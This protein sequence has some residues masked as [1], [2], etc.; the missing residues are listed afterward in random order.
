MADSGIRAHQEW[1]G[2]IQPVGLVVAPSALVAAQVELDRSLSAKWLAYDALL[3]DL[4]GEPTLTDFATFAREFLEWQPSQF[5][6]SPGGPPFPSEVSIALPELDARLEPTYAVPDPHREGQ[7]LLLIKVEAVGVALDRA[8]EGEA[9]GSAW[10]ASPHDRFERLLREAGVP[11][12]LLVSGDTIR[13]VYAPR[14][15]SSG[16]L[17]FPV[18]AMATPHGRP[19]L[20]ALYEMLKQWRL[21]RACPEAR[22]LRRLLEDSRKYQNE[23]STRLAEQVL[24]ALYELARGFQVAD[25]SAD[26]EVL[27][28]TLREA[29]SEIYGGLLATIMRLV[30]VLYAEERAMLPPDSAWVE[31]YGVGSLLDRLRA[32]KARYPDTMDQ[33]YGAWPRLLTLFRILHDGASHE[34]ILIPSRAGELFDPD[35]YPFLEGRPLH[36]RRVMGERLAR[37]PRLSDGTLLRVLER[38]LVLDEERLSYRALDVEQIG[39]VY[40]AMMGFEVRAALGTSIAVKPKTRKPGS[41]SH[42]VLNLDALL[43]IAP[44]RRAKWLKE[45]TEC[46][47]PTSDATALS[48][49]TD[50][51][52]LLAA[53]DR[54]ISPYTPQPVRRGGLILSPTE[55]RRR[56]GSHYTPRELTEPII[57][58]TLR[59]VLEA[60]GDAPTPAQLLDLRI[61]DPAMGSG[62]FL[63]GACRYLGDKLVEAWQRDG[64]MPSIPPDEEP[65]LFARRVVAQRCLFGVDRNPFA[66]QLAKLSLW[67]V[68]LARAHPFTFL[69]HALRCGDSLVGLT[70]SQIEAF[71]WDLARQS[72]LWASRV[73]DRVS[74]AEGRRRQIESLAE[75]DDTREKRRLLEQADDAL[76]LVRLIGNAA[77]AAFFNEEKPK[78]R[79]ERRVEHEQLVARSLDATLADGP[80]EAITEELQAAEPPIVPFHWEI[81]F[82]EVFERP[83]PGF[84]SIIGNPPFLGGKRISTAHG[85]SYKEWLAAIHSGA[86]GNT[87]LV[88]HFFRRAHSLL[89]SNGTFGLIATNTISQGDTRV[90]GLGWLCEHGCTIYEA[91]K[92]LK[93]PGHAAVVVSV[94]HV[95]KAAL[96][97]LFYLDD[98]QVERITAFLFH[99][100]SNRDPE[101][102]SVN[103]GLSFNGSFLSGIGFTFDDSNADATPI[104]EM[105]ELIRR[106]R[107]NQE[108]I[109]PFIGGEEVNDSPIQRHHRFVINF[110][111]KTENEARKWP[112]LM[113]IVERKVRPHRETVNRDSHRLR[114][115]QF[116]EKRPELY[117]AIASLDRVIVNSQVS[118]H[119]AFAFQPTDRVF[120]HTL[121]VFVLDTYAA[122]A[123]LQCRVHEIWSR[124]LGSSMKDDLRYTPSDCFETFPFAEDW[125]ATPRLE[126]VGAQYYEFRAQLM[127]AHNE[128]LTRTYNRFNDRDERDPDILSLRVLHD[129]MD[130]AVLD[131]YGWTDIEPTCEFLLEYEDDEE[132]SSRR[133][134]P[135]RYRWA[136]EVRDEV[137]ARLLE[138]NRE[139]AGLPKSAQPAR[140]T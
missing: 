25:D 57:V 32:D 34:R 18:A 119:V 8:G 56:S 44:D 49:A 67:L 11:A 33:R 130:R 105:E 1:L 38:L 13:F 123:V 87:D 10:N 21:S 135:W 74:Q 132:D 42:S 5:A 55:E 4:D 134:K 104:A 127:I 139:R 88:A 2:L 124:F 35:R 12:G 24:G 19:M 69:D 138:L 107:R 68:T 41:P 121:N 40:E 54:R 90:G 60:F 16:W 9:A 72:T 22:G 128:G 61:C 64:S 95:G 133:R 63:V 86:S 66:V 115:W 94:V 58:T 70:K 53:L 92:R 110:R 75:T 98:R 39:S 7:W 20:A 62:A 83:N 51:S 45:D 29:P 37:V 118:T 129:A 126:A 23:V 48:R 85:N 106:D 100:G 91:R 3:E 36:T 140:S 136:E 79:E 99:A 31:H 6:G 89:R 102:L 46:E 131:A 93:W 137:L 113:T 81:E 15:E 80:L 125:M 71:H 84:D 109:M 78:R 103:D 26:G 28:H 122:L 117:A 52:G 96:E 43:A 27:Q 76:H 17:S 116:G 82:P 120:A 50:V 114:W 30:F 101:R 108:V 65:Q 59:P 47:L 112:D 77:V 111:D 73:T 97:G 14:G